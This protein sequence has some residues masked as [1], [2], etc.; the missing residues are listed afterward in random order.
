L[1][2]NNMNAVN[3]NKRRQRVHEFMKKDK[4]EIK[5]MVSTLLKA[6]EKL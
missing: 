5:L 4:N 3:T 6:K 2:E 1:N